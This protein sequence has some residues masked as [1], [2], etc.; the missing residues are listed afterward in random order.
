MDA[1]RHKA[2]EEAALWLGKIDRGLRPHEGAGLRK[3]LKSSAN[4]E[5]I[6]DLARSWH[7]PEAMA[8][9]SELIPT[10]LQI[11]ARNQRRGLVNI[12]SAFAI[13]VCVV[14]VATWMFSNQRVWTRLL[15]SNPASHD[16][17]GARPIRP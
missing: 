10:N 12:V 9:L 6:V 4:R 1:D 16:S 7:S 3:W 11:R 13:A 8:L 15:A 5:A 2:R 17:R 14:V